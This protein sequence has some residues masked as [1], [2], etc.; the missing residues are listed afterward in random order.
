MKHSIFGVA[1]KLKMVLVAVITLSFLISNI[2]AC[3]EN[4][5]N[6][7]DCSDDWAKCATNFCCG[8]I[9]DSTTGAFQ[10]YRCVSSTQ[11]SYGTSSTVSCV[12]NVDNNAK[13]K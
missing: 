10:Y 8:K 2:T 9:V 6:E 3:S 11:T 12:T 1:I 13:K 4:C 7:S 5:P